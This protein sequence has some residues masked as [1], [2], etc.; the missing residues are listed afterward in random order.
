MNLR[1]RRKETPTANITPLV[2]VVLLLL[3]FFVLST[4]FDQQSR[5]KV[6]LPEAS[7]EPREETEKKV[8]NITIDAEGRFFV[9]DAEV[10][11]RSIDT[12]KA[13]IQDAL[14]HAQVLPVVINADANTP[15]Q[16][17]ITAMDAASQL[18]LMQMTFPTRLPAAEN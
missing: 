9:N 4:T 10:I 5:I 18:G 13:A 7:A 8:L 3:L 16:A 15:H 11:N 12:L 14:G 17:V 1:P 6:E 2:D